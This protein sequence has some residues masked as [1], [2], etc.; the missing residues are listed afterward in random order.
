[1]N[2]R[3]KWHDD[4]VMTYSKYADA[5]FDIQLERYGKPGRFWV[6]GDY[7]NGRSI[8]TQNWASTRGRLCGKWVHIYVERG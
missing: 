6:S 8:D 3:L 5:C 4:F 2:F 7:G 1:M